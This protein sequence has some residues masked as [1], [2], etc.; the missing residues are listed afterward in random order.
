[1]P[2]SVP[3]LHSLLIIRDGKMIVDA[4]FYPYDGTTPHNV[5]SVTKSVMTTL[6]GIAV[7]QGKLQLDQPVLSFFPDLTIANRDTRKEGITVAQLASNTSGLDCVWKPAE[8]TLAEM[9]KSSDWVQ[10]TLDLPMVADPGSTWEYCSPGFHLLSAI[11]TEVT[12]Q[13]ALDFAWENL[14]GPLGMRRD[15][16]HRCAGLYPRLGR[17]SI[18]IPGTWPNWVSSG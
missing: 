5:A 3:D 10:F 7:D 18:C 4:Y 14:F 17:I 2:K 9:E 11:L 6:I 12:G 1:M 15:F 8:P 16:A 13:T